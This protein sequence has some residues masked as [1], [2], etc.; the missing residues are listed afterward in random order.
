MRVNISKKTKDQT[1]SDGRICPIVDLPRYNLNAFE[2]GQPFMIKA[3]S[4]KAAY[5]VLENR[6]HCDD[7]INGWV[8]EQ[9]DNSAMQLTNGI[10]G[11]FDEITHQGTLIT[12]Y[13]GFVNPCDVRSVVKLSISIS[14]GMNFEFIPVDIRGDD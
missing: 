12:F 14:D 9:H 3:K 11:L 5:S 2:F 8:T 4:K 6:V 13:I 1:T 10:Y 7:S